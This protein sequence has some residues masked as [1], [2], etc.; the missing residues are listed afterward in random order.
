MRDDASS[1]PRRT[2][3]SSAAHS[4]RSSRETGNSRPF[5]VPAIVWPDRPTRCSSVAIR[6]GDPI[7]QTRSTDADVDAELQRRGRDQRAEPAALQPRLGVEPLLLRQ[8]AVMR[9]DRVLAEPLAQVPRHALRHPP[10]VDEHE[11]R[12]VLLDQLRS[13]A[14]K[15]SSQTSCDITA[16]SG[17]PRHLDA[18]IHRRGGGPRR[19]SRLQIADCRL[20]IAAC[21]PGTARPRRSASA[22]PTGRCAAAAAR[23]TCCRRSSDSARCAP[24]RVPITAWISSTITVR[25]RPQ[26]LAA[27]RGGQQQIQR[28]RRGHEDVRRRPQHRRPFRR[29]RVAGPH[30]GRDARRR[31]ARPLRRCARC[32]A[33]GSARFLWMSALS[34]FS[35]ET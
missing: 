32:R 9:G 19:R 12:A 23:A 7:W 10:R 6:F 21:R 25:D 15:Y 31:Q 11:R 3:R 34:A 2:A 27:A 22:S 29:R 17:E 13:G 30:R 20:Q 18:E 26:H 28:L 14:S 1:S 4:I 16:S 8:A 35:G 5:G 24:R 33:R